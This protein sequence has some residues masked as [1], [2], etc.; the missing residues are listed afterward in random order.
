MKKKLIGIVGWKIGD[1]SFGATIPY[2]H[3]LSHWGDVQILSPS[4]RIEDLDL[5]VLPGGQDT[6]SFRYGQPPSFYNSNPDAMKEYFLDNNLQAYIDKGTPI[7]GICLGMQMLNVK[8]GGSLTQNCYHPYSEKN[9]SELV[10]ELNFEPEFQHLVKELGYKLKK[11][12]GVEVNSLHHQGIEIFTDLSEDF[13]LIASYESVAEAFIH[14]NLAI[15]GVQ[16]HPEEIFDKLS[17]YLIEKLLNYGGKTEKSVKH[18]I[19]ES[20]Q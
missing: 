16:W 11:D 2:L 3:F 15:A 4:D 9:R 7:F 13:K 17:V 1:N 12:E 6:S 14:R 10:H 18:V 20:L 5:L 19:T 8:F